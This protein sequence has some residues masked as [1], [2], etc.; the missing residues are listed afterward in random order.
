M[1]F[2]PSKCLR[3]FC[4]TQKCL[5][6]FNTISCPHDCLPHGES[7]GLISSVENG[8]LRTGF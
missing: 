6:I 4:Y 7:Q 5:I 8:F 2:P 1:S 3:F